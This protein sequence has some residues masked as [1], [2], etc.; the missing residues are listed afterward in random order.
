M[1]P[2]RFLPATLILIRLSFTLLKHGHLSGAALSL[3][4]LQKAGWK[5]PPV[6]TE[7]HPSSVGM[8]WREVH[9]RGAEALKQG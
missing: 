4:L 5:M 2:K 3:T 9:L 7:V 6:R 8:L 1:A